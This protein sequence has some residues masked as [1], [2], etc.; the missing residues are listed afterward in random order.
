MFDKEK[1]MAVAYLS[2]TMAEQ[3]ESAKP[4]FVK[5]LGLDAQASNINMALQDAY[6]ATEKLEK[7]LQKTIGGIDALVD[8]ASDHIDKSR[9]KEWAAKYLEMSKNEKA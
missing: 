7:E 4:I 5:L 3:P 6:S 1:R 9:Q 8:L 2:K